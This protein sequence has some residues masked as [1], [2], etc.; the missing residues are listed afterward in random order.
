MELAGFLGLAAHQAH[1]T[2]VLAKVAEICERARK[3]YFA[4]NSDLEVFFDGVVDDVLRAD[5]PFKSYLEQH[6]KR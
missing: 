2:E 1:H 4:E 5:L 6:G 3:G